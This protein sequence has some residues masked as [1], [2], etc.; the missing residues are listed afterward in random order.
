M[1]LAERIVDILSETDKYCEEC[2]YESYADLTLEDL[3]YLAGENQ[4]SFD[5]LVAILRENF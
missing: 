5:G 3:D 1:N 4:I 2:M